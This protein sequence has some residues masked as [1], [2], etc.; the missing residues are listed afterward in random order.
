M[1]TPTKIELA[2]TNLRESTDRQLPPSPVKAAVQRSIDDL[3]YLIEVAKREPRFK[4]QDQPQI[5]LNE[6][7]GMT[8]GSLG[9]SKL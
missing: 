2:I 3:E 4:V 9:H 1:A 7:A 5:P 6:P 8:L